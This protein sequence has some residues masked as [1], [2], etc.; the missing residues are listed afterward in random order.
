MTLTTDT[1]GH[2]SGEKMS[3]AKPTAKKLL[4]SFDP[5]NPE[6]RGGGFVVPVVENGR[7]YFFDLKSRRVVEYAMMVFVGRQISA[8][9]LFAK[10]VDTGR[11]IPNVEETM[12]VLSRYVL[13]LSSYKVGN[14]VSIKVSES[15]N[16]AFQLVKLA[17][18]PSA[19][20]RTVGCGD[21]D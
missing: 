11:Q 20:S 13:E 19:A 7:V 1:I 6:G 16:G 15:G 12:A 17:D 8:N 3:E 4:T 21:Q 2:G 9:D 18:T 14:V 10:L 5:S